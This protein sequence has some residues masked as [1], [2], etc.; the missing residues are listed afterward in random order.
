MA[1]SYGTKL[2]EVLKRQIHSWGN[3]GDKLD[4]RVEKMIDMLKSG[5]FLNGD[6]E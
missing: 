4:A 3:N 1:V 6:P 5:G 2:R